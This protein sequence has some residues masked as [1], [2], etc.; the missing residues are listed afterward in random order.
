M[1]RTNNQL[2]LGDDAGVGRR[3]FLKFASLGGAAPLLA[4]SGSPQA[5]PPP[6][7]AAVGHGA[8][9]RGGSDDDV[10]GRMFG[11]RTII[12]A[13][14]PVTALGGTLLSKEVTD[15]MAAAS[16]N[17]VDLNELYLSAG[18]RLAKIL[19]SEAAM[20]TSG[21]SAAMTLAAA[22]CLTGG[23]RDRMAALP[24]PTW[25]R[26][27]ALIQR[28]HSTAYEQAYR[29][30]GMTLVHVDTEEQ[31]RAAIS[32]RTAMIG[33][34]INT[35]KMD[36]PGII[37][38]QRLVAIGKAAGVPVYF[39]ASFSVTHNS[40]PAS[41]WRYTQMGA[42]LVG[43]SGGKGLHGPQATGILA[44]RADLVAAAR[45]MASPNVPAL[46][47]GMK[48]DK[49][50]VVGLMTAIDQFLTRDAAALYRRDRARVATMKAYVNDIPGVRLDNEDLY[51]GPGLVLSWDQK[52]VPLSYGDFVQR[53]HESARPISVLIASGPTA[54]FGKVNGPALYAGYLADGEDIIVAKRAREI[55]LTARRA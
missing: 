55:L 50:G 34:L 3:G 2:T 22:A 17:F 30:A 51:F 37:P 44:G 24:Q 5:S 14:G 38:L 28:A 10:Y 46:G 47:R 33:G 12:N 39:D 45:N 6:K 23:D 19:K 27:E 54:Y 8:G 41:L 42:D 1:Q 18:A 36:L 53:M 13:A 16:R 40:P 9:A 32:E 31:M 25:A 21:A 29:D 11:V 20:V 15:A 7:P 49:E 52:D 43:I 4:W 26:R 48:V 35:E